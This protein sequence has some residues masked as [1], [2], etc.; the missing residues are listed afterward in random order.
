MIRS[1][2]F[3]GLTY[4]ILNV[5]IECVQFV[6]FG[7][8]FQRIDPILFGFLVFG[9]ACITLIAWTAWRS[10]EQLAAALAQPR[11]LIAVN[12]G[13]LVTFTCFLISVQLIEPAITY[14][15]SA[16]SMP[17]AA[18]ALRWFGMSEAQAMRN[19]TETLGLILLTAAIT[20][21]AVATI[22]G[23]TGFARGGMLATFIG[24]LF[25][26]MDGVFFT[27]I[28]IYSHR[29]NAAGVGP[30]AVL[31]L[32]MPFFVIATGAFSTTVTHTMALSETILYGIAGFALTIPPLYL[33]Q[34]AVPLISTLAL[35]VVFAFG[36]FA[37]FALQMIEGR[38]N[39]ATA[40]LIGLSIY[41]CGALFSAIGAISA[42][43]REK[44]AAA[45]A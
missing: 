12:L 23:Y 43:R 7:N 38:V 45:T 20:F 1:A 2:T 6:Y 42:S 35:S 31:G 19:R 33:L 21:L 37:V 41:S 25:A 13:A 5:L 22:T 27:L 3:L 17:L 15:V 9:L 44:R 26:V 10:P 18:F 39:F 8:L 28:L 30:A 34:K 32:R 11:N 40:T 24:I 14:T 4:A 16:G 36:P 29:L